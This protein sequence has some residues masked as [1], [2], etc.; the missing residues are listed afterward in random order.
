LEDVKKMNYKQKIYCI[1]TILLVLSLFC[2]IVIL[3]NQYVY[4]LP[5]YA[6]KLPNSSSYIYTQTYDTSGQA[7]HPDILVF[8]NGYTNK[9]SKSYTYI[10]ANTPIPNSDNSYEHPCITVSIK[11]NGSFV[12]D[13]IINPIRPTYHILDEEPKDYHL[14]Y[15]ADPDILYVNQVF[16][17]YW[18][19]RESILWEFYRQTSVDLINWTEAEQCNVSGLLT[20]FHNQLSPAIIFDGIWKMWTCDK[21][22]HA[23]IYFES[24]D[25]MNWIAKIKTDIPIPIDYNSQSNVYAWHI[26]VQKLKKS[27]QYWAV[28]STLSDGG[29][30]NLYFSAS[31]NGKN[32]TTFATPLLNCSEYSWDNRLYRSTFAIYQN[33]L[34]LWYSG[35]SG[36][37]IHIGYSEIE[38]GDII[39]EGEESFNVH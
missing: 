29:S 34:M 19:T 13:N 20:T 11:A 32:W 30:C 8:K 22:S 39:L 1:A 3:K 21:E 9:L 17:L 31:F 38:I 4:P 23:V 6:P 5:T 28:I 25:G 33:K 15:Q 26:D 2:T 24:V 37:Q 7:V 10:M 36:L 27:N 14:P 18:K 12:N 16:Y 35:I